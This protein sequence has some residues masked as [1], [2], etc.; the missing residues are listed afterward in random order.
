M[1][2]RNHAAYPGFSPVV[3][4]AM[5]RILVS[6]A[7]LALLCAPSAAS[8]ASSWTIKGAGWGHGIGMS[9]YGAYGQAQLG[10]NYQQILEH[11]YTGTV[12]SLS[13]QRT[14]RVL[15]LASRPRA[16][17]SGATKVGTRALQP[18][19]TYVA[20]RSAAGILLR[21]S[22]GKRV[23]TFGDV[24]L[25]VSSAT[26]YLRL[27][28]VGTYRGALELR[29]GTA[30]G[31]TAVNALS[32]DQYVQGVVPVEMPPN[33]AP[34]ALKAQAVAARSYALT[35]DAGGTVFDQ[36]ADTRS[37]VYR[38]VSGETAATNAAVRA[39]ANQIVTYHGQAVVT[40]FFSTSGGKTEDVQNVFYGALAVPYLKGVDDP[41][42]SIAPRHRWKFGP[43]TRKQV[44]SKLG[45]LCAG[46]FRSVDVRQRGASPRVVAADVVCSRGTRRVNGAQIR[47]AAGLYDTWFTFV[48]VDTTAARRPKVLGKTL[49]ALFFP[50]AVEGRV[51]PAPK[52]GSLVIVERRVGERWRR[53][54]SG[55]T[56]PDGAYDVRVANPGTYR[57]RVA[58][59]TGPGTPV[60]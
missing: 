25:T 17:F 26:G 40:Y 3:P 55:R 28:G 54:G 32:V 11:Y 59:V 31:V 4:P 20:T 42:D 39:T 29:Q 22:S 46:S 57:V 14:I 49:G 7:L 13:R 33:W 48:R 41:Y 51:D 5:R 24:P 44:K 52:A 21:D 43:Y 34:E 18:D 37:Q 45:G 2:A 35:T 36:F 56:A 27:N 16:T 1:D 60:R 15:L 58:G 30:G 8:A 47:S 50:R 10:R 38:G 12:V 9:Q 53:A 19:K 6:T 23:G